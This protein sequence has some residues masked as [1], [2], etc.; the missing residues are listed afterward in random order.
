MYFFDKFRDELPTHVYE[1]YNKEHHITDIFKLVY[2]AVQENDYIVIKWVYINYPEILHDILSK[3]Y[4]DWFDI[5]LLPIDFFDI[6]IYNLRTPTIHD[7]NLFNYLQLNPTWIYNKY[8]IK[9]INDC[10]CTRIKR[11]IN[12]NECMDILIDDSDKI[13]SDSDRYTD[14]SLLLD[15]INIV[16]SNIDRYEFTKTYIPSIIQ[17][18][19]KNIIKLSHTQHQLLLTNINFKTPLSI[20]IIDLYFNTFTVSGSFNRLYLTHYIIIF[21]NTAIINLQPHILE[22]IITKIYQCKLNNDIKKYMQNAIYKINIVPLFQ[23]INTKLQEYFDEINYSKIDTSQKQNGETYTII[24][25]VNNTINI[26]DI[27]NTYFYQPYNIKPH[28]DTLVLENEL[29]E[30]L[31]YPQLHPLLSSLLDNLMTDIYD[32]SVFKIHF[33]NDIYNIIQDIIVHS[34]HPFQCVEFFLEFICNI[35]D[36]ILPNHTHINTL[37]IDICNKYR[38]SDLESNPITFF[39]RCELQIPSLFTQLYK[40]NTHHEPLIKDSLGISCIYPNYIQF[41]EWYF[42]KIM[43]KN[44]KNL[45]SIA[46]KL[47]LNY[48]KTDNIHAFEWILKN[49]S[50]P[51]DLFIDKTII[52][53][54]LVSNSLSILYFLHHN[55]EYFTLKPYSDIIL[56]NKHDMY[57]MQLHVYNI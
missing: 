22:H 25:I 12:T 20:N 17:T 56:S 23:T 1:T 55:T 3:H 4:H 36:G 31:L 39:E 13:N 5:L 34:P 50:N 37:F 38:P 52:K 49:I 41:L 47:M 48:S 54:C 32:F 19:Y 9:I 15:Y 35:H 29:K 57:R 45:D 8:I 42:I 14:M 43:N 53:Q 51:H 7:V 24:N 46:K 26:L 33:S 6:L 18:I 2:I 44:Q 11:F 10:D 40:N 28:I 16:Y 30:F 27:F 21:I